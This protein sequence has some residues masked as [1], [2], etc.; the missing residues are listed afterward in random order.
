MTFLWVLL[1]Q[2]PIISLD[3]FKPLLLA[4]ASRQIVEFSVQK[5]LSVVGVRVQGVLIV[6]HLIRKTPHVVVLNIIYQHSLNPSSTDIAETLL[7]V[8]LAWYYC[9]F[10]LLG[11]EETSDEGLCYSDDLS[12]ELVWI[13]PLILGK[14]SWLVLKID[15]AEEPILGIN[16]V[17]LSF[18]SELSVSNSKTR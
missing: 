17:G 3:D 16:D 6:D 2:F 8:L 1:T 15:G 14:E 13:L 5:I 9:V 12:L 7:N 18:E 10:A 4:L 11:F